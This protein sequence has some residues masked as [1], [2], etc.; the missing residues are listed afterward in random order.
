MKEIADAVTDPSLPAYEIDDQLSVLNG[1]I[2][3]A[4]FDELSKMT[5][6]GAGQTLIYRRGF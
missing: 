2:D 6:D 5:R 3:G 4:L 1:R